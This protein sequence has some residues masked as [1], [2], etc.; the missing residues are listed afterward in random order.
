MSE[1]IV[2]GPD[3]YIYKVYKNPVGIWSVIIRDSDGKSI[4]FAATNRAGL[5]PYRM[6][7]QVL[8]LL[9]RV[10]DRMTLDSSTRRNLDAC[11]AD[12][13]VYFPGGGYPQGNSL[14]AS[15]IANF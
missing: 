9:K 10:R 1:E 2:L 12:F 3:P 8:P 5:R 14:S 13:S 11:I 15:H 4:A 6:S 7:S